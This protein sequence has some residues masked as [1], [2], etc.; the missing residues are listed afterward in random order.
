MYRQFR[1]C[2]GETFIC[3]ISYDSEGRVNGLSIDEREW[4]G[5][6]CRGVCRQVY[7]VNR[8]VTNE[9][10]VYRIEKLSIDMCEFDREVI[11]IND[12]YR[13]VQIYLEPVIQEIDTLG[14]SWR[15]IVITSNDDIWG[16]Y[17][18]CEGKDNGYDKE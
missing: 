4:E 9:G 10:V 17:P 11:G 6:V 18:Q 7:I 16:S 3:N 15:C 5:E 2:R 14:N 8:S 12:F 1:L 13:E